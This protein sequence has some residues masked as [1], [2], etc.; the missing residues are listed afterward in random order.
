LPSYAASAH[1]ATPGLRKFT[2]PFRLADST[3]ST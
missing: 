1:D 3:F 2:L